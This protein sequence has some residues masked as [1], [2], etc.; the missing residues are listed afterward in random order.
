MRP[1]MQLF[2][3]YFHQFTYAMVLYSYFT[4]IFKLVIDLKLSHIL[5]SITTVCT[6][7]TLLSL[8]LQ[9]EF[10]FS[11]ISSFIFCMVL[12][13]QCSRIQKNVISAGS[14]AD[15]VRLQYLLCDVG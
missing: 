3:N 8:I 2:P 5:K 10:I 6:I 15:M 9:F 12:I 4:L 1:E 14:R 7:N 13:N 11:L